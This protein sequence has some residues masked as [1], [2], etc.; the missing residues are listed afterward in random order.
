MPLQSKDK[1]HDKFPN[2]DISTKERDHCI[3]SQYRIIKKLH[4]EKITNTESLFKFLDKE[5]NNISTILEY[6]MD[7]N[8]NKM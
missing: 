2:I 8:P 5:G 1:F 6:N 4:S 3:R 7:Y